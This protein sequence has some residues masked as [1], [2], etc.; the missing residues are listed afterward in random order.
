MHPILADWRRL[1]LQLA[2]SSALGAVLGVL[3]RIVDGVPWLDAF[4]FALPLALFATPL[5]FS[6]W[7]LCR[8]LP[9]SRTPPLR[10][11]TVALGSGAVAG[12][13]WAA[14][15]YEWWD[16]LSRSG[17][18]RTGVPAPV[19]GA[20]L[21]GLGGLGY[22]LSVAV[23]YLLQASED[24]A[25]AGRRVL[26]SEIAHRE[27]EL[28]ALR[29]QVDPHFLFNS[30]NSI[31]GLTNADPERA[32]EMCQR[33]ADFLR[34]SLAVGASPRI[35]LQREV[36]LAEQYLNVEQARFGQR[37]AIRASVAAASADVP[38]P[39]LILQPLVENAVRHGIATCLDG[40]TIEIAARRAGERVVIEVVNPRDVEGG[41][42]GTGLG[43]DLV[44]R[45]L[46][47]SFG[48]D[49]ALRVEPSPSGYRVSVTIPVG[50]RTSVPGGREDNESGLRQGSGQARR[51][52]AEAASSAGAARAGVG[53]QKQ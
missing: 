30:L 33:L 28:R 3:I 17:W 24:S 31:A 53:P 50:E 43:L 35:S 52:Q 37:L 48:G 44:R 18:E 40:G 22:V 11:V 29:A 9:I 14:I 1:Q 41:R 38:V 13:L 21:A 23:H 6:A 15:G 20:L 2:A 46:A 8:A 39:P 19:L 10:L 32:R 45:R 51:G 7:Y 42:A 27:A 26:A 12:A 16:V 34:E 47:A 4:V 5:S 36:A 49:A 25:E